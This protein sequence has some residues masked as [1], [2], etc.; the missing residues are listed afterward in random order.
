MCWSWQMQPP[1]SGANCNTCEQ[2]LFASVFRRRHTSGKQN[3]Y[4]KPFLC[5]TV[6]GSQFRLEDWG[7]GLHFSKQ[8]FYLRSLAFTSQVLLCSLTLG[9]TSSI[10]SIYKFL[11]HRKKQILIEKS[12]ESVGAFSS[13]ISQRS[14]PTEPDFLLIESS[15]PVIHLP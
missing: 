13:L 8:T 1:V 12:W 15:K 11:F 2:L 6:Q 4:Q 7:G 3:L 10:K 9:R 5:F 14:R